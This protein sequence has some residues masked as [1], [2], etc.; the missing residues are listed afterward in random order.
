MTQTECID[1]SLKTKQSKNDINSPSSGEGSSNVALISKE[2]DSELLCEEQSS[3]LP[4]DDFS[5]FNVDKDG[6]LSTDLFQDVRVCVFPKN[7]HGMHW[8]KYLILKN[9]EDWLQK[10]S[11]AQNPQDINLTWS[12]K[13]L[14]SRNTNTSIA[15]SGFGD[16]AE[17]F[18]KSYILE[19]NSKQQQQKTEEKKKIL[20]DMHQVI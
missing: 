18:F 14:Q 9:L 4:E 13:L 2:S 7:N 16:E 19:I 5:V 8:T 11:N 3:Y 15:S 12:P 1:Q 20:V 6:N 17:C 10:V